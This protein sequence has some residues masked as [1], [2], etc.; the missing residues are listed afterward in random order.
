MFQGHIR[1]FP[2]CSDSMECRDA[3]TARVMYG[4]VVN[5]EQM[6]LRKA[7]V[8]INH[9]VD[10]DCHSRLATNGLRQ[11]FR[12]REGKWVKLENVEK[13][14]ERVRNPQGGNC[15]LRE[16]EQEQN[17]RFKEDEEYQQNEEDEE[18]EDVEDE[19]E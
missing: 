6:A 17:R 14:H 8:R 16:V 9:L 13:R 12:C 11:S 18:D 2:D 15:E 19:D 5:E 10:A 4:V 7:K 3:V 1:I